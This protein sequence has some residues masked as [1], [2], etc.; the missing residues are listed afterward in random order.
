MRELTRIVKE[1]QRFTNIKSNFLTRYFDEILRFLIFIAIYL[2]FRRN[3]WE[4]LDDYSANVRTDYA[5]PSRWDR[6]KL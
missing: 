6:L 4:V 5:H 3:D 2:Y 1:I